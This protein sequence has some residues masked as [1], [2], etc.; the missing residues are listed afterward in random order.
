M[1]LAS[2]IPSFHAKTKEYQFFNIL[3]LLR[4]FSN[5]TREFKKTK[6]FKTSLKILNLLVQT[7]FREDH[8][9]KLKNRLNLSAI[10]FF[11]NLQ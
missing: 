5:Q 6:L 4:D 3:V 7:S 2:I 11:S 8:G 10:W 9:R 1:I